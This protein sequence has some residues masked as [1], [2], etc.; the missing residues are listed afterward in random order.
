[1]AHRRDVEVCEYLW[2]SLFFCHLLSSFWFSVRQLDMFG[3]ADLAL[4]RF[5]LCLVLIESFRVWSAC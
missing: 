4:L 3:P 2:R 5:Y 1:M